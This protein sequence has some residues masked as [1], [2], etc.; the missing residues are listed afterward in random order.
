MKASGTG[1]GGIWH[2]AI[3]GLLKD[4]GIDPM[5]C[6]GCRSNGAAPGLQDM[7]AAASTSCPALIPEA[8]SMI[9][10]GK[11]ARARYHGC[12]P[13]R[14]LPGPADAQ[15]GSSHQLADRSLGA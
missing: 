8:R 7:V 11:G 14:A 10:A 4:Q 13:A 12:K 9:D 1:Q 15:A 5:R 2:L 3:A 6:H